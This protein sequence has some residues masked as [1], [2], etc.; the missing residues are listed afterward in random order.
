MML[1]VSARGALQRGMPDKPPFDWVPL[2]ILVS[3]AAAGLAFWQLFPKLYA[4]SIQVQCIAEG[5]TDCVAA[6]R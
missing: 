2:I 3:V 6:Q 5:R 1:A 4:H